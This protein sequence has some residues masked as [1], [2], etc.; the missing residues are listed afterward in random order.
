M[1][2]PRVGEANYPD[3]PVAPVDAERVSVYGNSVNS[4][5]PGES[6]E[7]TLNGQT[8]IFHTVTALALLLSATT[9]NVPTLWNPS[10]SGKIFI[11]KRLICTYL[12]GT[13][14]IGGVLLAQTQAQAG[15]AV[16]AT[17]GP[18][19]TFTEG[20]SSTTKFNGGIGAPNAKP[21]AM[22][23]APA[24]CTFVA[25]PTVYSATDINFGA[26]SP[27]N[28]GNKFVHEFKGEQILW[29]GYAMSV[30]YSVTTSTAVFFVTLVGIEKDIRTMR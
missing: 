13:T 2:S 16:I 14:T 4:M 5:T 10:T 30:V 20:A 25:A 9:G 27:T 7:D 6:F 17:N 8:Q 3:N 19:I 22:K 28:G 1:A 29:P 18:I 23:W 21:S 15:T 26:A 12:S 24:V 11:P